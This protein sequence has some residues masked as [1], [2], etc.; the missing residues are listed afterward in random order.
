MCNKI[1]EDCFLE[2]DPNAC[3]TIPEILLEKYYAVFYDDTYYIGR[4]VEQSNNQ[5]KM[6]FFKYELNS[7]IWPRDE[8]VTFVTTKYIFYGPIELVG[9]GPFALKNSDLEAIHKKVQTKKT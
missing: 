2:N 5:V 6:K 9:T 8:D 1:K 3:D 4:V 7:F